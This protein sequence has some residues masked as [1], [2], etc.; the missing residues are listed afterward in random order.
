MATSMVVDF[1]KGQKA[2]DSVFKTSNEAKAEITK[3]GKDTVIDGTIG[4]MM[5]E[6]GQI[7]FCRQ[8]KRNF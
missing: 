8:L 6:E 2:L 3:Y 4:T 1:E 5:D 7:I